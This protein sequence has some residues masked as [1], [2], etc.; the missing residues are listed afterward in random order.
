[1]AIER[2]GVVK[3]GGVDQTVVGPDLKPGDPAPDFVAVGNDW[4]DVHPIRASAGKVIVVASILS[5]ETDVCDREV[6]RFNIEASG[7]GPDVHVYVLSMDLPYTQKRWCGA[8]GVDRVTT[9]SDSTHADFGPRYGCL[10]K[11]KRVL[12]RA[13]FVV[14]RDGKVTYADYMA[15][16][17]DEPRYDDVLAAVKKAI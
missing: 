4:S 11:E 2:F 13:M 14:G 16:L 9:V 6:R 15:A 8:A 7:L 3:F 1:M 5:F 10:V 17:G 12:R